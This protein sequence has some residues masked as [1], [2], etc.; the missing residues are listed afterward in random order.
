MGNLLAFALPLLMCSSV[1]Q[2]TNP[3]DFDAKSCDA[4]NKYLAEQ[5]AFQNRP[6]VQYEMP[7]RYTG[8]YNDCPDGKEIEGLS[9]EASVTFTKTGKTTLIKLAPRA[10]SLEYPRDEPPAS[11][12]T[13]RSFGSDDGASVTVYSSAD[14]PTSTLSIRLGDDS[15]SA[16]MIPAFRTDALASGKDVDLGEVLLVR[17]DK[18]G[19]N[20]V[21]VPVKLTIR[22]VKP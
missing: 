14:R 15:S 17:L 19:Q 22:S 7:P 18:N 2:A 12:Y 4:W 3:C 9:L 11:P 16:T 8:K 1:V 21:V 6:K 10:C 13:T 20:G 5:Q